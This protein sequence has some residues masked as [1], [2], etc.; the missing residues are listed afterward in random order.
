M[1]LNNMADWAVW[2]WDGGTEDRSC[3]QSTG[4]EQRVLEVIVLMN[5]TVTTSAHQFPHLRKQLAVAYSVPM[6][7]KRS[8]ESQMLLLEVSGG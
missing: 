4:I 2:W 5:V 7:V 6:W 8:A 3:C 1:G